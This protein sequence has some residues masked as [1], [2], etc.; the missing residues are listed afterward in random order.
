M[1]VHKIDYGQRVYQGTLDA[2]RQVI[3]ATMLV[4]DSYNG[5]TIGEPWISVHKF[6]K[7]ILFLLE[8]GELVHVSVESVLDDVPDCGY[9]R[10][11]GLL[12]RIQGIRS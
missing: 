4:I 12:H 8:S 5:E 2:I 3:I 7:E 1:Q 10:K 11:S 6:G 9:L